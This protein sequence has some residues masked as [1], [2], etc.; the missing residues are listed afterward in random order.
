MKRWIVALLVLL[1][2]IVLVSPGIVGQLAEQNLR[3]GI[4]RAESG[5]GDVAVTEESFQ[6]YWFTT[7]GRHRI[8]LDDGKRRARVTG[9]LGLEEGDPVPALIVDTRMDH[10]LV[11]VTSMSRKSGSLMPALAS[12]LSTVQLDMG[13]GHLI[14]IPA[15]LYSQ[16]GLT[17]STSSRYLLETGSVE[18]G[19]AMLEW[20]GADISLAA[21][22]LRRNLEYEGT[23]QPFSAAFADRALSLGLTVF[24]GQSR[25]TEV[26]LAVGDL[27]LRVDSMTLSIDDGSRTKVGTG[28]VAVDATSDIVDGRVTGK[29]TMAIADVFLPG[30]GPIDV[31]M[32]ASASGFEAAPLH[33]IIRELERAQGTEDP[34]AAMTET[35]SR[36]EG[37]VERLLSSGG[38]FRIDRLDVTL[39]Q[40]EVTTRLH[41]A[42]PESDLAGAGFSWPALILAL[43]ASADVRLPVALMELAQ[44]ANPQSGALVAMGILKLD[45][46]SY[47]VNAEYR[48]GLLTVNGA[49][50][51]IPLPAR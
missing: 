24:E 8:E 4:R 19:G 6:R 51:P 23:V 35:Y 27:A 12:T 21:D 33:A 20:E 22:R 31:V 32:D 15:T 1:A 50:M 42:L 41:V 29:A 7:E 16:V 18:V 13:D 3:E 46:D 36:I 2:V 26:G 28:K 14:D 37:D 30:A 17:G 39:P 48:K 5:S 34:S 44:A 10:G 11:P 9:L 43:R 45:G 38:E 49:P 47:V 40:G 25:Q